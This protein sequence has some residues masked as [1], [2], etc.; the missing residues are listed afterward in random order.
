M[1]QIIGIFSV[2]LLISVFSLSEPP[3]KND[4][5]NFEDPEIKQ[6]DSL[7]LV[8]EKID[9]ELN[10]KLEKKAVAYKDSTVNLKSSVD[11]LD[12]LISVKDK[13]ISN[14]SS[15]LENKPK[16]EV[17]TDTIV[18]Y[19]VVKEKKSFLGLGENKIDTIK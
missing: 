18:K 15:K 17:K 14:M 6:L 8:A 3:E 16:I 1:K 11:S 4:F 2:G 19:I 5:Q 13:N 7:F 9:K 10:H 12:S